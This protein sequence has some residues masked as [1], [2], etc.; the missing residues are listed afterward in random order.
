MSGH[1]V[2]IERDVAASPEEVWRVLTDLDHAAETLSGVSRV[3]LLTEGPY[4]V[5]TRWR[6]TRKMFGK[7]A[8]EE[9]RVTAVEAPA[10]TTVEADSA[11]VNYVTV[12]T[13]TPT[14]DGT[15]LAM[16]FTARQPD[17][18]RVQKLTW[19]V[20]GKLGIKATSKMMARDLEDI[21]RRAESKS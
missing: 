16:T 3:E 10:R 8:T 20:F 14:G 7:E 13:L 2:Q 19:V 12:F 5:G 6:E 9:M 18:S 15:R 21:A 17:P 1:Q 11:G 4:T